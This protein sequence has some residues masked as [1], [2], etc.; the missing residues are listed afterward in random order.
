MKV[1]ITSKNFNASDHLKQTIE[2]K[3]DR[4]GKYFSNDIVANVTLT[5]EK[6]RQTIEATINAKGTIFRAEETNNDAY[7]GVD[8]VVEKLSSQMSRFKTKLQRKHKDH[9]EFL[10]AEVPDAAVEEAD[11]MRVV[12]TKKFDLLPM[13]VD[14]AIMQMELLEHNF[15][16]FLNMESDSVNVVYKRKD[17]TYGL[18]ETHY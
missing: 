6:G 4:L 3:F 14:E 16:V 7:N 5:M 1:I 11:E 12:K 10:F 17:N 13:S 8:R 9:K 15:F 18:L 2:T